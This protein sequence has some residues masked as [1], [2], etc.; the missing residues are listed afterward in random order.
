MIFA[1]ARPEL[2]YVIILLQKRHSH[3]CVLEVLVRHISVLL[4]GVRVARCSLSCVRPVSVLHCLMIELVAVNYTQ[5][6]LQVR[7]L[8]HVD[9]ATNSLDPSQ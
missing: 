8:D 1:N 3:V 5:E 6:G 7:R 9:S 2:D 4:F